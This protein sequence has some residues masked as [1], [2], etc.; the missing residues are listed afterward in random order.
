MTSVDK[1]FMS[2]AL[3]VIFALGVCYWKA[4]DHDIEM[5]KLGYEQNYNGR[6]TVWVKNHSIKAE[7]SK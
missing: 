1:V 3:A 7:E 5:A 6:A 2:I 4:C